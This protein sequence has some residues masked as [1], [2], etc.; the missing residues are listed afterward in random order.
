[1]IESIW[2]ILGKPVM[3]PSLGG[4]RLFKGN[5]ITLCGILT[6]VPTIAQEE[7]TEE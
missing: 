7:S 2:E 6:H 1:M 3:I 5:M 4:I